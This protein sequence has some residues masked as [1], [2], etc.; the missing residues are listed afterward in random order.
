MPYYFYHKSSIWNLNAIFYQRIYQQL[1]VGLIFEKLKNPFW[2]ILSYFYIRV[3]TSNDQPILTFAILPPS[4]FQIYHL[5]PFLIYCS[6]F[7]IRMFLFLTAQRSLHSIYFV[8]R[9]LQNIGLLIYIHCVPISNDP[10]NVSSL[11]CYVFQSNLFPHITLLCVSIIF[12]SYPVFMK[13]RQLQKHK[14]M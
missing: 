6:I 2:G 9:V 10:P 1:L 5:L 11:Y 8:R 3:S 13:T 4:F 12:I 7:L 14:V